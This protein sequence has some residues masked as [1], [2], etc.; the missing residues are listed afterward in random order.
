[1]AVLCWGC[2]GMVVL[3]AGQEC[4]QR[5]ST[6]IQES[7]ARSSR[8][9]SSCSRPSG[10]HRKNNPLPPQSLTSLRKSTWKTWSQLVKNCMEKKPFGKG[11]SLKISFA[12]VLALKCT[13]HDI[14]S[15]VVSFSNGACVDG[16]SLQAISRTSAW[17]RSRLK[18]N[19][20]RRLKVKLEVE[21]KRVERNDVK[22][23]NKSSLFWAKFISELF[24]ANIANVCASIKLYWQGSHAVLKKYWILKSVFKTLTKFNLAKMYIKYWKDCPEE[25][26]LNRW[27][28]RRLI[29]TW[30]IEKV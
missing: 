23:S 10:A 26:H 18:R 24:I 30:S 9:F 11:F 20:A 29:C 21:V 7:T 15:T 17:T 8:R 25:A 13:A 27:A 14:L 4:H 1:M 22:L 28:K 6:L 19:Q 2:S 3:V 12:A 5:F 16:S